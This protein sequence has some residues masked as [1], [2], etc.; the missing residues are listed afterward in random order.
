MFLAPFLSFLI[1]SSDSTPPSPNN[2]PWNISEFLANPNAEPA[3]IPPRGPRGVI[4]PATAPP[5]PNFLISGTAFIISLLIRPSSCLIIFPFSSTWTFPFSVTAE[6]KIIEENASVDLVSDEAAPT[7]APSN[8]PPTS[9][10]NPPPIT[11]LEATEPK[12]SAR[13]LSSSKSLQS[14]FVINS[15][16]LFVSSSDSC[17]G[18]NLSLVSAFLLILLRYLL[19]LAACLALVEALAGFTTTPPLGTV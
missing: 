15:A 1:F 14:L 10:P 6:P 12:N 11:P 19:S 16:N 4:N 8:G 3:S 17:I 7:A 9:K 2:E 13:C 5:R 18:V